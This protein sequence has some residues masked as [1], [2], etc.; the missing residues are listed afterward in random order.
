[1][2][3]AGVLIGLLVIS[4]VTIASWPEKSSVDVTPPEV[5]R[6]QVEAL[7]GQSL[8]NADRAES[9]LLL[10]IALESSS[11]ID[12][13][14]SNNIGI[15]WVVGESASYW[16]LLLK[17]G[18]RRVEVLVNNALLL[19]FSQGSKPSRS[20]RTQGATVLLKQAADLGYWPAQTYLGER[21]IEELSQPNSPPNSAGLNRSSKF[22]QAFQYLSGCAKAG[23]AACHFKLG[24]WYASVGQ[25]K[26]AEP[27]LKA[28]IEVIR[29][30]RRYLSSQ[31]V[32]MD[33]FDALEM[34]TQPT[35]SKTEAETRL[36]SSFKH[37]LQQLINQQE[38]TL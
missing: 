12:N 32:L 36:Y 23:F 28:G 30:D 31:P 21:F 29:R 1:M 33:T 14:W 27:L 19:M 7:F 17:Q 10:A 9:L 35:V 3:K 8:E 16:A 18:D 34:L 5:T 20:I 22:E 13:Q 15:P 25:V 37:T 6:D 26:A 38:K 2:L 11:S 4:N 24:F